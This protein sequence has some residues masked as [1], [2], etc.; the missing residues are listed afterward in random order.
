MYLKSIVVNGFKSFAE[1]VNIDLSNK[2]N[3]VVGPNGSGKSNVVDAISWVLGT[4]S[5]GAL[6]TNKMEDVIFAGTEK[7]SEKG[8]AE[9]YLNFVVDADKFNGSEEISIG[10][11]LYRDGASEYFMNG[12]NC[13]LLDI[14]EFLSDLGIGK[15]QHTIISQGQIAEILLSLI[16]ISE[17]TRPY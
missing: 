4:Q 15:Q 13:R 8:F 16:H 6:R 17:P 14:Q 1:R 3:V 2:V 7:L 11:K 9:V 12:L 10:R 5:P